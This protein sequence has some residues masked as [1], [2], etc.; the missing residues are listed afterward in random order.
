M[1]G[2]LHNLQPAILILNQHRSNFEFGDLPGERR[3]FGS[4]DFEVDPKLHLAEPREAIRGDIARS[5][6]YF[7]TRYG[8]QLNS[9]EQ[10]LFE[11]WNRLDPPDAWEV[12]RNQLIGKITGHENPFIK[13]VTPPAV[14]PDPETDFDAAP[15]TQ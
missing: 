14:P 6:L 9:A 1:E 7:Q 4:C 3:D 11:R 2:D 8:M 5:Y 13:M 15:H 12:E 10:Q